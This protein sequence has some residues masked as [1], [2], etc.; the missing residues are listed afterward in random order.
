MDAVLQAGI[1]CILDES[2]QV[3]AS[4]GLWSLEVGCLVL[5]NH[6]P[7]CGGELSSFAAI[8][9]QPVIEKIFPRLGLQARALPR[10]R[11]RRQALQAA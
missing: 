1:A 2:R 11:A 10:E 6:C 7:N 3:A 5:L 4:L 9:G 8:L